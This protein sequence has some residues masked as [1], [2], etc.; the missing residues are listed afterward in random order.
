MHGFIRP[1]CLDLRAKANKEGHLGRPSDQIYSIFIS[2]IDSIHYLENKFDTNQ[3]KS[4]AA[5]QWK[6]IW[7]W[8]NFHIY[9]RER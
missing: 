7:T 5:V 8:T 9:N 1:Q 4:F 2:T 3:V 6:Q